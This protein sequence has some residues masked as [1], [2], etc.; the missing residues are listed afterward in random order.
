[1]KKFDKYILTAIPYALS[2]V[3]LTSCNNSKVN[4]TTNEV[5]PTKQIEEEIKNTVTEAPKLISCQTLIDGAS[6]LN[7]SIREERVIDG[8]INPDAA[9]AAGILKFILGMYGMT[10]DDYNNK[11]LA[12]ILR[13]IRNG[14][15]AILNLVLSLDNTRDKCSITCEMLEEYVEDL[16]EQG[17]TSE[18]IDILCN[19]LIKNSFEGI[20]QPAEGTFTRVDGKSLEM[21]YE[22]KIKGNMTR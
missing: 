22:Y 12:E 17:Y 13:E 19:N 5:T 8:S 10:I 1:M 14:N 15:K 20:T 4:N 6:A 11:G 2:F 3:V 9:E 21:W 7:E 18:E 16:R